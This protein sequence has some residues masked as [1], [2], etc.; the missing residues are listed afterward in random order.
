MQRDSGCAYAGGIADARDAHPEVADL[1]AGGD[2]P[3]PARC[4]H[5]DDRAHLGDCATPRLRDG[6]PRCERESC[7]PGGC[8][9][10]CGIG[11]L[12]CVAGAA[13]PARVHGEACRQVPWRGCRCGCRRGLSREGHSAVHTQTGCGVRRSGGHGACPRGCGQPRE[14]AVAAGA[15]IP[16]ISKLTR[17]SSVGLSAIAAGDK[18]S[19]LIFL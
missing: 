7:G 17:R 15:G 12:Q 4:G 13:L 9:A 2:R 18:P 1:A 19:D 5:D 8:G 16:I 3:A 10:C 11:D 6:R 14:G